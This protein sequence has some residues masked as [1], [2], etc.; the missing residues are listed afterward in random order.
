MLIKKILPIIALGILTASTANAGNKL[1]F[2]R[3]RSFPQQYFQMYDLNQDYQ[4]PKEEYFRACVKLGD[5]PDVQSAKEWYE[6]LFKID[7]KN[8]DGIIIPKELE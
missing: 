1:D 4:I 3:L 8:N 5:A 2:Q 6:D 7:D